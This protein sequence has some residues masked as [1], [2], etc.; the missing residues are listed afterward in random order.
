MNDLES[1][2]RRDLPAVAVAIL[3]DHEPDAPQAQP[4]SDPDLQRTTRARLSTPPT[5]RSSRLRPIAGVAASLIVVAGAVGAV[6]LGIRT[7]QPE[8]PSAANQPTERIPPIAPATTVAPAQTGP[9]WFTTIS[10]L[11]PDE[12]TLLGLIQSDASSVYFEAVDPATSRTLSINISRGAQDPDPSGAL[13]IAE[14]RTTDWANVDPTDI[15]VSLLDGRQV[16]VG[17]FVNALDEPDCPPIN[18]TT[19]EPEVLGE[20][21]VSLADQLAADDLP[22]PS[23]SLD[24]VSLDQIATAVA[25]VLEVDEQYSVSA[26]PFAF[27]FAAYGDIDG[28]TVVHVRT[29]SGLAPTRVDQPTG[30]EIELPERRITWAT[31]DDGTVWTITTSLGLPPETG[32]QILAAALEV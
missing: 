7:R 2:L 21:A 31:L 15:N 14:A 3:T 5:V 13:P 9:V 20:L 28:D 26:P 19:I 25:S 24:H 17:C 18:G 23:D 12:F 27:S 16:S 30:D 6:A 11:L 4:A 29:V 32:R 8:E 1:R 22:P 10:D